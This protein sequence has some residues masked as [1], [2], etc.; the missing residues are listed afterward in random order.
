VKSIVVIVA[1]QPVP[2]QVKTRLCSHLSPV[3][4]AEL[5]AL[6]L[7]DMVEEMLELRRPRHGF[8]SEVAL[9]VSYTPEESEAAFKAILPADIPIF[10]QTGDSLGERLVNIFERLCG[11]G[12]D[13]V[14]IIGSDCPD[15]PSSLVAE[16]IRLLENPQTDLVLGPCRDGGYYL[17]GMKKPNPSL[18]D[19]IPWSTDRV[20]E[21]TLDRARARSL[22]F[23]LLDRWEDVDTYEDLL[24]FFQ[25]NLNWGGTGRRVGWRTFKYLMERAG[26]LGIEVS[27]RKNPA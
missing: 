4:A 17:V 6:F 3:E 18:F 24:R 22:S 5:Y 20:L 7:Q 11:N 27:V 12:Y 16:S 25:R 26:H 2:A 14:H 15:M 9:T 19:R 1:K 13:Q 23:S 21:V 8:V 10:P